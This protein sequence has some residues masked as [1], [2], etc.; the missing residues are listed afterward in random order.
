MPHCPLPRFQSPRHCTH[1]TCGVRRIYAAVIY[2][3]A[4]AR[5]RISRVRVGLIRMSFHSTDV[6]SSFVVVNKKRSSSG[7]SSP[8]EFLVGYCLISD[9]GTYRFEQLFQGFYSLGLQLCPGGNWSIEPTTLITSL[10]LYRYATAPP[11]INAIIF[12]VIFILV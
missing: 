11:V 6:R 7:I 5:V 8:D 12:I 4:V 10:A 1:K 9:R 3:Y 2:F